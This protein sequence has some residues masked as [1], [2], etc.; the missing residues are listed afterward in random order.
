MDWPSV[1]TIILG[2]SVLGAVLTSLTSWVVS[3]RQR[4]RHNQYLALT[5]AHALE[6][7]SYDCMNAV[8]DHD[9]Y[10]QSGGN[11][12]KALGYP[13][14]VIKLPDE[15]FKDFDLVLLDA[16]LAFPQR[17]AFAREEVS[18][19]ADVA[20]DDAASEKSY[21]NTIKLA[22]EAVVLAATLR[23]HYQL[24]HR[25]LNFGEYDLRKVIDEK[26]TNQAPRVAT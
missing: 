25:D 12:G 16:V 9:L 1:L 22:N 4:K 8:N 14:E 26:V 2:S 21:E 6:R 20:D 19:L 13:P 5:L 24:P 10:H 3:S 17:V 11:A 18:N 23:A 15:P 7:Y